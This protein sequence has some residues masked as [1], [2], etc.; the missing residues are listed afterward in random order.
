MGSPGLGTGNSGQRLGITEPISLGGPT[1]YDVI[2]TR[3]LEKYL[4]N[5]GLYESQEE[6]VSREEVLGRLDQIVKNWVKA[7][8]RAKGL[9]EQLVQE[10]NAK[11]FTFGSYRLGVH[12]PGADID[13]LCV[14]PR[15]ATREEDFFGELHKMLSEMPEVSE[16]H[17]VPDAHVPIMKFKFKGVSIDLLYAKLSL[18]VIPEDLDISQDSILQNTDD[19]TVRSLNGCRVTDQILRLVPNIQ[20]FRTTLRCMRF[21][22]KRRGVYSNVAGFLGGINWAL[23]VARICQ[24]YPNALPN[25]LVSRFFRV[26][27]QWRWPNPVM[28]CAIKEGSLGLQVWD[29]RKNPKDRYHLMPIITPAY[30]SMNSSYNVSSSTLRIMTDEFQRGSEICE[31]MEANK[32]DWDALFEAYAFFEAYKN[33]LQID[34]SAE[35]DDDL[36]NW[37]GWVESRLRQLTLKIERH[38]YNMLQCHPHP[39]DFQD[40]SRPFHCSYFMGLQRKQGVPVNEG[41]QFDIRL[42]VE[43][44]K[45]SVNTYTL[46]K[47]G[48]EIRVSHVK[49]RSIPSFVFPGGVRPSR[50]SKAT[51]DSRRASDAK[52]SGHAGSD[53]SGEV[54]GAADGQVDGKKRKRADDNA[55]TQLKNSKYIT[56]VPSSSAE[57][58]V[59]SPGGTVTPC[60]LKGDNVDATGLV[61]PTRGKDESNM[62]NGSKNSSTEELSSLN[63]EVD[64]SLRYIPPH[65][66]LHVTTDASSS[67]EA[68]KL[69]IEQIMSGPYVSDQAF[70]EEP[71]ELED[72][73]EF[74][75]QVVSVGNTNNGSQQAPV[76]DAAGAAPIISSNGAGPS[77]SLHASGSIE[78]LEPAELTAM[79]SIPVAPVVQKKPLIRLNFTSLGK[80]SEKSG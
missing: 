68:E 35:N 45:H 25:M 3:E 79:T 30:P 26:Y 59:G 69:A 76:S 31:A 41:E 10:A 36:R 62:T 40:N 55:D 16:L 17:P 51:W 1:E 71:E 18:W 29:P 58:Q 15:H 80:A 64:G 4:Q 5:V 19:Q 22:A 53:K 2:K 39:G 66:G 72:D 43:E 78:E 12:G 48:M 73:L 47:P 8:S 52:V 46:W 6:A 32:A 54:K 42:T 49:R 34:I 57:V 20:N 11:I 44:F 77:I 27:T 61:E 70:P 67:K 21:W 75:N 14:G 7:I 74:R 23:L 28:L 38:T 56:A 13:T 9:N 65:K 24:L 60:S 50:P 37:K 33:Y 63:S